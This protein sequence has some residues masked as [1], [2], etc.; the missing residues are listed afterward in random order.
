M[1]LPNVTANGH[2]A[3]PMGGELDAESGWGGGGGGLSKI[4]K[5]REDTRVV[6]YSRVGL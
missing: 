6:S 5:R 1:P 3:F 2:P 4:T